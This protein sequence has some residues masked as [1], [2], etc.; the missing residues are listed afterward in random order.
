MN[1]TVFNQFVLQ[2]AIKMIVTRKIFIQLQVETILYPLQQTRLETNY[3]LSKLQIQLACQ[4][5]ST[6]LRKK[7]MQSLKEIQREHVDFLYPVIH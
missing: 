5:S 7:Y 4:K 6:L 1:D 3:L 2:L